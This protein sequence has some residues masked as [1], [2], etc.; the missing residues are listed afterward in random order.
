MSPTTEPTHHQDQDS[1]GTSGVFTTAPSTPAAP[2]STI[3][4]RVVETLG[5]EAVPPV[6]QTMLKSL[7]NTYVLWF[8][9]GL[10]GFH[11]F[12]L[13]NPS[14]GIAYL[15]TFGLFGL[16]WVVDFWR[17]PRLVKEANLKIEARWMWEH[18]IANL[19]SDEEVPKFDYEIPK[20][21][22]DCYL[23]G[24]LTGVLGHHHHYLGRHGWGLLYL[25]TVGLFGVGFISD[26]FRMPIL[27]KRYN[28]KKAQ[29]RAGLK[30]SPKYHLDDAYIMAIPGGLLGFHNF[31]LGRYPWGILYLFSFG[32]V[33]VGW[34][35]DLIRLPY[36]VEDANLRVASGLSPLS[37]G[38]AQGAKYCSIDESTPQIDPNYSDYNSGQLHYNAGISS[39][40]DSDSQSVVS[41]R[42]MN[43]RQGQVMPPRSAGLP[44][45]PPPYI[46]QAAST[47]PWKS[48]I[49]TGEPLSG[50]EHDQ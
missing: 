47:D 31:Y 48:L 45:P 1:A 25:V 50:I 43:T 49:D 2:P 17:M 16:G 27:L 46:P 26:W 3:P 37:L 21:L 36:L 6:P 7:G 10:I 14:Y 33:G 24:S 23:L 39:A 41:R 42:G 5:S 15:T 9:F 12:Y 30:E 11:H 13:G 40:T 32:M 18:E 4:S 38:I 29:R 22:S 44:E 34:L 35:V 20:Q 19:P 8:P 28:T